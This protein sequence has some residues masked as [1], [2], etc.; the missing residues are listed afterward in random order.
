M[1]TCRICKDSEVDVKRTICA[2]C[3][4]EQ[5]RYERADAKF[6]AWIELYKMQEEHNEMV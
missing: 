2:R 5:Q 6:K 3:R 1:R 4:E